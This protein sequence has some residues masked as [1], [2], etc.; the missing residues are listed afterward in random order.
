MLDLKKSK[1]QL[2]IAILIFEKFLER[3]NNAI[4]PYNNELFEILHFD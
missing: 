4:Q 2:N 3:S 1:I